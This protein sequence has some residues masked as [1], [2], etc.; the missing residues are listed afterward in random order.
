M[1]SLNWSV[2]KKI[3]YLLTYVFD[4]PVSFISTLRE[5][6]AEVVASCSTMEFIN[7]YII[8]IKVTEYLGNDYMQNSSIRVLQ[9]NG[10]LIQSGI[11]PLF[12]GNGDVAVGGYR[13][14][15]TDLYMIGVN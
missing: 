12:W 11:R 13:R 5:K 8:S 4:T 1:Y 15:H 14:A 3:F 9:I 2:I 7:D 6:F 10:A